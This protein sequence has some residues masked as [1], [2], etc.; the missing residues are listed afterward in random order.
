MSL[1]DN[2]KE[3]ALVHCEAFSPLPSLR[4]GRWR[5]SCVACENWA[6]HT[7]ERWGYSL[8]GS[9]ATFF[10]LWSRL[11]KN[12]REYMKSLHRRGSHFLWYAAS[13]NKLD[14]LSKTTNVR[15][16]FTVHDNLLVQFCSETDTMQI[17]NNGGVRGRCWSSEQHSSALC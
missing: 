2:G 13:W 15:I 6:I 12:K 9:G 5:S 3:A 10:V 14:Q 4:T 11:E 1:S 8:Q 16:F 7:P 17:D